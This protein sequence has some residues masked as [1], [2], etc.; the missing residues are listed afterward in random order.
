MKRTVFFGN[1][2]S[3]KSTFAKAQSGLLNCAHMD[4][5]TIAWAPN[6]DTPTRRSLSAARPDILEFIGEKQSWVIEGCYI[7]LLEVATA[8]ATQIVFL[9]PGID[10][11]VQNARSRPWE[12]HK[13]DS[14]E[15]QDANLEMLVSW[16]R[17]Y[18]QRTDDSSYS[19][20]RTLFDSF[21]GPK[22]EFLSNER[23][24]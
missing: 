14:P 13:Y 16:I 12:P 3:G 9:N 8:H 15:A 17:E 23:G 11:C 22:Q 24:D 6:S 18:D 19:A 21:A 20:H 1:S 10:V 7:S 4:L 2:G 5:D